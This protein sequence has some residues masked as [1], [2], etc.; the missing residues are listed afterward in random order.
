MWKHGKEGE[1]HSRWETAWTKDLA[2]EMTMA[3]SGTVRGQ[4]GVEGLAGDQA[5]GW[6]LGLSR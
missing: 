2:V 1:G 3:L 6:T 4:A 5:S